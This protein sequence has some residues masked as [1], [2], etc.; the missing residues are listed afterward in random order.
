MSLTLT[1]FKQ[2]IDPKILERGRAYWHSGNIVDIWCDED[3]LRWEA[4]VEGSYQYHVS[5]EQM[6]AGHLICS[7][8][9]PYDMGPHCKHIAAVLFHIEEEL[10]PNFEVKIQQ[11]AQRWQQRCDQLKQRLEKMP[12]AQ[13]VASLVDLA[14]LEHDFYYQLVSYLA[15]HR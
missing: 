4:E 6:T 9:C 7:C 10:P 8:N 11:K 3:E 1:N 2:Q 13:L 14:S 5:I 15:D 12:P